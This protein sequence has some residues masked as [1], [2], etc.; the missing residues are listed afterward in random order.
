M[1]DKNII[2]L[3]PKHL[4]SCPECGG[5]QFFVEAQ[6]IHFD[7]NGAE[8]EI[9]GL[10]CVSNDCNYLIEVNPNQQPEM[11]FQPD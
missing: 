2:D 11:E 10:K 8:M 6:Y 3:H 9:V 5:V 4:A 1:V 7:L